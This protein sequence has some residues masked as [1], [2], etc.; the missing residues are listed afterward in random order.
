MGSRIRFR[1]AVL[2]AFYALLPF[3]WGAASCA[4]NP[5]RLGARDL[6]ILRADGSSVTLRAEIADN[7]AERQRGLMHR[8]EVRD[9]EG[10]LFVFESDQ[11]LSF[12]MKNTLVPLSIAYIASDGRILEFH[13]MTPLSLAPVNSERSVRYA[14]EVPQGW[15]SRAR[16]SIGDRLILGEN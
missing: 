14:L 10:M 15:F 13:D 16:L 4:E 12:W 2:F 5:A 9:G 11:P 7:D 6:S 3:T 1:A 8:K